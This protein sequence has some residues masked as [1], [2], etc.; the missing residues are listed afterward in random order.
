[1][2]L[3]DRR[4]GLLFAVFFAL[5]AI[6]GLRS[7][8]LGTVKASSLKQ[9]AVTQQVSTVEVP[10]R[11]GAIVDRQGVRLAVS[12]PANDIAATP[13][14]IQDPAGTA[15]KLSK[16]LGVDEDRLLRDLS[17]R[18]TGFVYLARAVP[19]SLADKVA[20]LE[21]EGID[22]ISA[23]RRTYPRSWLASQVLGTVGIDGQ[24]LSGLEYAADDL[25]R[26]RDGRRR[27]T[28]DAIGQP[29]EVEEEVTARPGKTLRLTL[30]AAI[31]SKA[32]AV[33]GGVGQV[34]K[35]KGATA[36]VMDPDTGEILAL[37]N[38]PRVDANDPAGA[39]EYARQN[40]AT[41]TTYEPGSTFKAFTVAGAL[42]DGKVTPETTFNLAPTIQVADRTIG[43]SHERGWATMTTG[44][45]LAQSSNVGAITIGL[46]LGKRRFDHWVRTFGF[47][48]PTGVD[49]P[50]E[51]RGIVPTP[52][53][54]SG[55]SMGNLPIGQGLA[56]TPMQMVA[57]YGAIANGGVLRTP[58]VIK[59]AGGREVRPA[60]GRRV[61]SA[62]TAAQVRDMLKGVLSPD[63]TASE[64]SVP[65][66][67][68]AGKTGTANKVDPETGEYSK[69][70]YIASFVGFAPADDPKLL[71]AVI[72]DEP[73][74]AYY[75]G[76]V[77]APAFGQIMGFALPYLRIAPK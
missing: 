59:E 29:I 55:S 20:E 14:L 57:A 63:G 44:Q 11:R 32:E 17:R 5:L 26:G 9:A 31:Q 73:Q 25:L 38:W 61:I 37:A 24:G 35:P 8:F 36:I 2:G 43:E 34:Y 75:G 71:C 68:L 22:L 76:Q 64:V 18:D 41:G 52:E 50:G 49:L 51:E 65:G 19:A 74:G 27:I 56:V 72:V 12:E 23:S 67:E 39:P 30:D 66:Y 3:T 16:I 42:E 54:Y 77:A 70:R 60:R 7:G 48:E 53:E 4:I 58:H 45:I 1:M 21:I 47:G 46:R 40:L 69:S 28:Q 62:R 15:E 13:Y 10:A 33:L 6:A